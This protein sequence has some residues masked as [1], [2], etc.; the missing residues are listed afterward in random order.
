MGVYLESSKTL[1]VLSFDLSAGK[2]NPY[3]LYPNTGWKYPSKL[4]SFF[5]VVQ[6]Y[7][8]LFIYENDIQNR[9]NV[10][11][12]CG[13]EHFSVP[14]MFSSLKCIIKCLKS[15]L[16]ICFCALF[17]IFAILYSS[18]RHS[19]M[20]LVFKKALWTHQGQHKCSGCL[21]R[22]GHELHWPCLWSLL[23]GHVCLKGVWLTGIFFFVCLFSFEFWF[24]L[25]FFF[26]LNKNGEKWLPLPLTR[27]SKLCSGNNCCG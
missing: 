26:N 16:R 4:G 12:I 27:H 2:W 21:S 25:G 22:S 14:G 15:F 24:G 10:V 9:E 5:V 3:G 6:M 20:N 19:I 1:L 17:P 18:L 7:K 11:M 8:G 23:L 13:E